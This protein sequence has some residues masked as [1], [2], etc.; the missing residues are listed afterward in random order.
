MKR[1]DVRLPTGI[2]LN[3]TKYKEENFNSKLPI[4]LALQFLLKIGT[5]V[6]FALTAEIVSEIVEIVN[7][8]RPDD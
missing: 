7:H 5:Y 3:I 6:D 2:Q 8:D 1:S 4:L